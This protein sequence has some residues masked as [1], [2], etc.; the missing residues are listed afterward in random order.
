MVAIAIV[1]KLNQFTNT[2]IELDFRQH[3]RFKAISLSFFEKS[4]IFSGL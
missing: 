2:A 1:R 4:E 3:F